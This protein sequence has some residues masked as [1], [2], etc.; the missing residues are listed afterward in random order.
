MSSDDDR[1]TDEADSGD[2]AAESG[3]YLAFRCG[4]C[5]LNYQWDAGE[6]C[7]QEGCEQVGRLCPGCWEEHTCEVA[8][9]FVMPKK[10]APVGVLMTRAYNFDDDDKAAPATAVAET[11]GPGANRAIRKGDR[12]RV[13]VPLLEALQAQ[14]G[15]SMLV[16][17]FDVLEQM[18]GTKDLILVGTNGLKA[19]ISDERKRG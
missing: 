19:A 7:E 15:V 4:V 10:P 6:E 13:S 9:D 17:V 2:P 12:M 16:E 3:E 1:I 18:D 5:D 8:A 14:G 11:D